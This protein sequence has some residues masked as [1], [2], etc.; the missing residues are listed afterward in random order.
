ML[1]TPVGAQIIDFTRNHRRLFLNAMIKFWTIGDDYCLWFCFFFSKPCSCLNQ[2]ELRAVK[3]MGKG[4]VTL[5]MFVVC[6]VALMLH[7]YL[8]VQIIINRSMITFQ[9]IHRGELHAIPKRFVCHNS[10]SSI[11]SKFTKSI[12]G[13]YKHTKSVPVSCNHH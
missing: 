5:L 1:H 6:T 9:S 7:A 3:K 13:L 11:I 12:F 10:H 4:A 2:Y 8:F